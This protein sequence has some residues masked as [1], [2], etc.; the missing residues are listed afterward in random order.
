MDAPAIN[1]TAIA[2]TDIDSSA[3]SIVPGWVVG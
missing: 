2:R 3:A 1:V